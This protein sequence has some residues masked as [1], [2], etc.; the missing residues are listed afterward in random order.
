MQAS[1][2]PLRSH[3]NWMDPVHFIEEL[4]CDTLLWLAFD[5]AGAPRYPPKR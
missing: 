5:S 2:L 1:F 4:G 3:E